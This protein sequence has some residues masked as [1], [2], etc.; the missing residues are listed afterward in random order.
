[1]NA[2]V[3]KMFA[4]IFAVPLLW[5]AWAFLIGAFDSRDFPTA[6]GWI[7]LPFGSLMVLF[8]W[9]DRAQN[10]KRAPDEQ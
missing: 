2:N 1:M 4:G 9:L 5:L 3:F 6:L 7:I 8:L 10:K